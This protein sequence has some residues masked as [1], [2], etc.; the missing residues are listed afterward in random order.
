MCLPR[1]MNALREGWLLE[2]NEE[3][4]QEIPCL[5]LSMDQSGAQ[6]GKIISTVWL[7]QEGGTP[8]RG[9]IA[10]DGE[11][12]LTAE[13]TSFAFCDTVEETLPEDG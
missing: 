13:F 11:T 4:W 1:L 3:T 2:E 10:V 6:G 9:E 7:S 12:I 5:R 8:V